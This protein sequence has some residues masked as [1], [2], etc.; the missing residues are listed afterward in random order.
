MV[1]EVFAAAQ[2]Q[3]GHLAQLFDDEKNVAARRGQSGADGCAAQVDYAQPFL[4]LEGAPAVAGKGLGVRAELRTKG[5]RNSFHHFGFPEGW[6]VGK[7]FFQ[8]LE[9]ALEGFNL[10]G[11]FA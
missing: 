3:S 10:F 9:G 6:N 11:Q 7:L 2:P 5:Q 1:D 8:L 4:A